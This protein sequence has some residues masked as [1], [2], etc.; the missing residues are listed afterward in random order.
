LC[1]SLS[2]LSKGA[3][4]G[5]LGY[6]PRSATEFVASQ[7]NG[8]VSYHNILLSPVD[9]LALGYFLRSV[10]FTT[11][12]EF[13]VSF[14][15]CQLNDY[16]VSFLVRELSKCGSSSDINSM[17]ATDGGAPGCLDL[18]LDWQ[19]EPKVREIAELLI[20]CFLIGKLSL[21]GCE[22]TGE[23]AQFLSAELSK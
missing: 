18:D 12:G 16:R 17:A 22:V 8:G 10:C 11:S 3:I 20:G 23:E 1:N 7:L 2:V 19:I 4:H 9:C 13:K 14:A 6:P 15:K 5:Y 21:Q